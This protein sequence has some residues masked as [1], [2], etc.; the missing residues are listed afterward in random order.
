M[1][2]L[3]LIVLEHGFNC[4]TGRYN[5]QMRLMSRYGFKEPCR[6]LD[7]LAVWL[8]LLATSVS[9]RLPELLL[10]TD[11]LCGHGHHLFGL[12]RLV[13][14]SAWFVLDLWWKKCVLS[15]IDKQAIWHVTRLIALES[16]IDRDDSDS[17]TW[18]WPLSG[19]I[20][21]KM[22]QEP[23]CHSQHTMLSSS[24]W[25]DS[26]IETQNCG[27]VPYHEIRNTILCW[28]YLISHFEIFHDIPT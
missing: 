12:L 27:P 14:T 5:H 15:G 26:R 3:A 28:F 20:Y 23:W 22:Y 24:K 17:L 7:F 2:Q 8:Y 6:L 11:L 10:N 25:S 9:Y 16:I 4:T 18:M 1:D 21:G 19:Y 13:F